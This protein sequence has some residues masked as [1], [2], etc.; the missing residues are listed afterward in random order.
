MFYV[1]ESEEKSRYGGL[2]LNQLK[3]ISR[4]SK[5]L[6]IFTSLATTAN[7]FA[8]QIADVVAEELDKVAPLRTGRQP[9][10]ATKWLSPAAIEVK[11][12]R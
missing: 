11:R 7:E 1:V 12:S 10:P 4:V 2:I 6:A 9:N 3:K 5:K 8:D